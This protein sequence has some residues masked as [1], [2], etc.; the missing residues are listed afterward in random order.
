M[1]LPELRVHLFAMSQPRADEVLEIVEATLGVG[2]NVDAYYGIATD[3]LSTPS[4]WAERFVERQS[5]HV[6]V[7]RAMPAKAAVLCGELFRRAYDMSKV[8]IIP[9]HWELIDPRFLGRV[10]GYGVNFVIRTFDGL[11]E[12]LDA[13]RD[14]FLPAASPDSGGPLVH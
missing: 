11:R 10:R 1:S 2:C 13:T 9:E 14:D 8:I 6:M 12:T 3:D 5:P 7:I 4:E